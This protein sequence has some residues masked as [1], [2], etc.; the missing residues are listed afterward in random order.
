MFDPERQCARGATV[1][2]WDGFPN[3]SFLSEEC[4]RVYGHGRYRRGRAER[5]VVIFWS[6]LLGNVCEQ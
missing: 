4:S 3:V 1:S 5:E 2:N 6:R